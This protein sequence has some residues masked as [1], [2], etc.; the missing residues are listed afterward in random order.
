M[1]K[2]G[3]WKIEFYRDARGRSPVEE[4]LRTLDG[5]MRAKVARSVS[6]LEELGTRLG[7]P[8]SR[9]VR[10]YRFSELRVQTGGNI[11]RVFY[12]ARAGRRIV[13]LH[14]FAKRTQRTPV[15]ELV[16]ASGRW[17]E[18]VRNSA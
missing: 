15:R 9:P 10:G 14:A 6:L 16:I 5:K 1:S 7:M 2:S 12:F 17:S 4:F 11:V 13:L 8:H 18:A 3:D